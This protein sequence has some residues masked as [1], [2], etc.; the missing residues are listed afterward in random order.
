MAVNREGEKGDVLSLDI[1]T[2]SEDLDLIRQ[3]QRSRQDRE[4]G[5]VYAREAGLEYLQAFVCF[6]SGFLISI[7]NDI[8][9]RTCGSETKG[10]S[11]Q[12]GLPRIAAQ[13]SLVRAGQ[14]YTP[15]DYR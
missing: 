5:R 7:P 6:N 1:S 4:H 2:L 10:R 11:E 3:V 14:R 15:G 9:N 13:E 12:S 8:Q